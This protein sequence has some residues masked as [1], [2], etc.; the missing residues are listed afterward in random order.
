MLPQ[1]NLA[2]KGLLINLT[3]MTG[4]I[5]FLV[6]DQGKN[7]IYGHSIV[8]EM[9]DPNKKGNDAWCKTTEY[10]YMHLIVGYTTVYIVRLYIKTYSW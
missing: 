5:N 4:H 7:S 9:L 2:R 6:A 1:Q 3:S 10:K 8:S